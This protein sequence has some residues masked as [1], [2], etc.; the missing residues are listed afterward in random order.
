MM[1]GYVHDTTKIWRIWD[2]EFKKVVQCS[3]VKFDEGRTAYISCLDNERDALGLPGKEPT[4]VEELKPA[5]RESLKPA[6]EESLPEPVGAVESSPKPA[7]GS[8]LKTVGQVPD[9]VAATGS[10]TGVRNIA[11]QVPDGVAAAAR[12]G[13]RS[14]GACS[15]GACSTGARSTGTRSTGAR[16]TGARSTDMEL[17]RSTRSTR[18]G[19][20]FALAVNG[21]LFA[22]V[23]AELS[24]DP[25][26]Y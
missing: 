20:L 15:T 6:N 16:S 17:R 19:E 24:N 12:T 2:P 14:T 3:D 26:S 18:T 4:Y 22:L 10:R 23:A 11:G 7:T 5:D 25:Q 13:R 1:V 8:P 9:E 21:E